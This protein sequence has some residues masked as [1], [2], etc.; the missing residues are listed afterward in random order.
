[1]RERKRG[2]ELVGGGV[3]LG[4]RVGCLEVLVLYMM[5]ILHCDMWYGS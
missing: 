5:D 3:R 2:K 1:M 4:G